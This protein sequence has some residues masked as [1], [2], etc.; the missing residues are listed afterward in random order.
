MEKVGD[1]LGSGNGVAED[2]LGLG[3][4]LGN[5]VAAINCEGRTASGKAQRDEVVDGDNVAAVAKQGGFRKWGK[6]EGRS[7]FLVDLRQL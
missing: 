4:N 1:V 2:V 3:E 6:E 5:I 7:Q